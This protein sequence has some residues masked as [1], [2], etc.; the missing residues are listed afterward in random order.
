MGQYYNICF[1]EEENKVASQKIFV[2]HWKMIQS[3]AEVFK[4]HFVFVQIQRADFSTCWYLCRISPQKVS[5]VSHLLKAINKLPMFWSTVFLFIFT[6]FFLKH[7][8]FDSFVDY[9]IDRKAVSLLAFQNPRCRTEKIL[10]TFVSAINR[11][12]CAFFQLHDFVL[13]IFK[14]LFYSFLK[15]YFKQVAMANVCLWL[16]AG[17]TLAF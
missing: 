12:F 14:L 7:L 4:Q 5:V 1:I 13:C 8:F 2:H 3:L 9:M 16:L 17:Y 10:K 15:C 6:W 11:I